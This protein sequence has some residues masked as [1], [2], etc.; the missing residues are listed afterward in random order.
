MCA[1][2]ICRM[3]QASLNGNRA[4]AKR[5]KQAPARAVGA[6]WQGKARPGDQSCHSK[7]VRGRAC[8]CQPPARRERATCRSDRDAPR[9]A[10][11]I[12]HQKEGKRR[13][14]KERT[15]ITGGVEVCGLAGVS[16]KGRRIP[17][18]APCFFLSIP[19]LCL[20]IAD[21]VGPRSFPPPFSASLREGGRRPS[22]TELNKMQE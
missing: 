8:H 18:P 6:R 7:K 4:R 9:K 21:L 3:S 19:L 14:G 1:F 17:H 13:I 5:P 10:S 11:A 12:T 16:E 15:H 2:H 22:F 20:Q